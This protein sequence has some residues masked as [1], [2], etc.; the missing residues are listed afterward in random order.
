MPKHNVAAFQI[1]RL[2]TSN[3]VLTTHGFVDLHVS[4]LHIASS[5]VPAQHIKVREHLFIYTATIVS[6]HQT[7]QQTLAFPRIP[8]VIKP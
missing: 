5:G 3:K 6:T 4:V 1:T 8:S 7:I 2:S